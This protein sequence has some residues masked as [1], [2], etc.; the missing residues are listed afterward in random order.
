MPEERE[1]L[2]RL[3]QGDY[4]AF[5]QLYQRY[6]IRLTG[7]IYRL[8]KSDELTEDILQDLFLKIWEMRG[9]IDPG[10]SF[11]SY[12][13]RIGENLVYDLYRRAARDEKLLDHFFLYNKRHYQHVE[14]AVFNKE[15]RSQLQQAI[16]SL[17][18]QCRKVFVLFQ[19]E[20][21]SYREI[22]EIMGIS[23]ST[24]NNHLVRAN[25]L[26]KSRLPSGNL[27]PLYMLSAAFF[28]GL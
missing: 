2:T 4:M 12:L 24:I 1:L 27:I 17:P 16:D 21:K 11:R 22:T 15:A 25:H 3:R 7:N 8:V 23:A 5:N 19:I 28:C 18:A 13:F 20:G 10:K 26:L 14:E 6:K 9:A